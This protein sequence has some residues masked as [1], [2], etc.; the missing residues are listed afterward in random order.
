MIKSIKE[1]RKL[2]DARTM[3]ENVERD[4]EG[5]AIIEMT[6]INDE[7][8]LSDF[9]AGKRLAISSE[10]A[11]FLQESA[12]DFLPK[13]PICLK[14]YSDCI[15]E[16]EQNTYS[17]ALREYYVRQYSQKKARYAAKFRD[18]CRYGCYRHGCDRGGA[19]LF[20]FEFISR[21]HRGDGYLCLGVFVGGGG[22]VLFAA[23]CNARGAQPLFTVC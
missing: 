19:C 5:R 1:L 18:F 8:F 13:E 15:D 6:V 12:A 10:V 7:A 11:D 20:V 14:I 16:S 22:S 21:Y 23:G 2:I 4:G 3:S 9:S 17:K